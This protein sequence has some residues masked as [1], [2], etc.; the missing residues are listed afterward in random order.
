TKDGG[1]GDVVLLKP[2]NADVRSFS[3]NGSNLPQLAPLQAPNAASGQAEDY[4]RARRNLPSA[5]NTPLPLFLSLCRSLRG[6][7]GS[8]DRSLLEQKCIATQAGSAVWLS[9]LREK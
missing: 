5:S 8:P 3:V 4:P 6:L 2:F 1:K 9:I 7:T